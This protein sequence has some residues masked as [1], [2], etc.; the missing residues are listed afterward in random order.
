MGGFYTAKRSS[1]LDMNRDQC[2]YTQIAKF[3]MGAGTYQ[4][5]RFSSI[6]QIYQDLEIRYSARVNSATNLTGLDLY[7]NFD[8]ASSSAF[9]GTYWQANSAGGHGCGSIATNAVRAGLLS[10]NTTTPNIPSNGVIMINNYTCT[11]FYKFSLQ[12]GAFV[13]TPNGNGQAWM[14]R[15]GIVWL[16]TQPI[17][18][19]LVAGEA[20]FLAGSTIT[21]YGVGR[22]Y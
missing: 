9:Y 18:S 15:N 10:A 8:Q 5:A 13:N 20:P 12:E 22:N 19:I 21:L 1:N 2:A 3:V 17:T 11:N 7:M 4:Y 16:S 14:E 6:P